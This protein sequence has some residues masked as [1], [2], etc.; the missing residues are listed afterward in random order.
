MANNSAALKQ[1]TSIPMP[2]ALD[3]FVGREV[4]SKGL[5]GLKF[6]DLIDGD[7]GKDASY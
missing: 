1:K 3:F 4:N 7:G 5:D 2:S 6:A